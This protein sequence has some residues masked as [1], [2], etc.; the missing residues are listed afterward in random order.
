MAAVKNVMDRYNL[1]IKSSSV[2]KLQLVMSKPIS[3]D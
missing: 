3:R 1:S 2:K